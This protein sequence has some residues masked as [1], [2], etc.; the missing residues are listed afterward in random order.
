MK[1]SSELIAAINESVLTHG[2]P[3][4]TK[5]IAMRLAQGTVLHH[6]TQINKDG[7]PLRI[8]INGK[9]QVWVRQPERFKLPVK[10]G[11]KQYG[12]IDQGNTTQWRIPK[13]VMACLSA[14]QGGD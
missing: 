2:Y 6:I 7:S 5:A 12:Y 14:M 3:A 11:L 13:E 8:R 9:C 10:H 1:L 4:I